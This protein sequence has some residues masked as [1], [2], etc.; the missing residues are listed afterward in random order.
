MKRNRAFRLFLPRLVNYLLFLG[1]SFLLGTGL[2]LV[3]RLPP[4]SR[5]GHGLRMLGLTRHQWGDLHFYVGLAMA[6]LILYH[7]ILHWA[8]VKN[9]IKSAK[10]RL[11]FLGL[12]VGLL[13]VVL[14]LLLPV[15]GP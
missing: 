3:L 15:T 6:A 11:G 8:W 9:A 4:G 2:A 14:P 5:G 13:I 7:L 1:S 12:G 10:A